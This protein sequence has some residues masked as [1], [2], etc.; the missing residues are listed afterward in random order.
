[1][2]QLET[3]PHRPDT[4]TGMSHYACCEDEPGELSSALCGHQDECDGEVAYE[5]D[6]VVCMDLFA[7]EHCPRYGVCRHMDGPA[8]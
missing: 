8:A 6:C 3:A 1:M 7:T 5:V 2:T 4:D